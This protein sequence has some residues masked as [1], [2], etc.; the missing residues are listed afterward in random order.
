MRDEGTDGKEPIV[1]TDE[2]L[3][4]LAKMVFAHYRQRGLGREDAQDLTSE[5]LQTAWRK[6]EDFDRRS[7][8]S[9]WVIGIAKQRY[10]RFDRD[11]RRLKRTG[12]EL[13]LDGETPPR[14]PRLHSRHSPEQT[15]LSRERLREVDR[16]LGE[17]PE[18][19]RQSLLLSAQGHSYAE[20]GD[21]LGSTE[22]QISSFV[23]Q[24]R[25]KLRR[26]FPEDAPG[27]TS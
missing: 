14:D 5:V 19:Q 23:H 21:L 26:R 1:L 13:E 8:L 7:K 27:A 20:I 24:A 3:R 11:R 6:L 16:A 4:S 25:R 12:T 15:V 18:N 10:L 22:A 2:Q 9:T 17:M